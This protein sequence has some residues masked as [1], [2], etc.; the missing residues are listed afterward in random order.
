MNEQEEIPKE[1]K[2]NISRLIAISFSAGL[3]GICVL[4]FRAYLYRPWWS[5]YVARNLELLLGTIGVIAG[6]WAVKKIYRRKRFSTL[7]I[8]IIFLFFQFLLN[9]II[10]PYSGSF[11]WGCIGL[12]SIACLACLLL[13]PVIHSINRWVYGITGK[14]KNDIFA[15]SGITIGLLLC[16]TWLSETSGPVQ[17]S[18]SMGCGGN[19]IK[20]GKAISIYSGSNH[21]LYPDPDQWCDLLLKSGQIKK[22]DLICPEIK[23]RWKRQF[24]PFPIPVNRK[25]Y[26]AINPNCEPNSPPDTVLLFEIKGGWNKSGGS[27]L[28]FTQNHFGGLC[29]VLF[30]NG[31]IEILYKPEEIA[32]LKWK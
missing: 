8:I 29:H 2:S 15:Y 26:Y 5:E 21:G 22:D 20:L 18:L 28:L 7:G 23:F 11:L 32:S 25:C 10:S 27:E 24:L 9:F 3:L 6:Y 31:D 4:L 13:F 19:L 14:I 12:A 16:G 30:K 17:T 1:A